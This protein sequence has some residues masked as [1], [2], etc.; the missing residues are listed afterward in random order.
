MV[1]HSHRSGCTDCHLLAAY[2]RGNK[3]SSNGLIPEQAIASNKH[4]LII[5]VYPQFAWLM[6]TFSNGGGVSSMQNPCPTKICSHFAPPLPSSS[7]H[8]LDVRKYH[9]N[10][11]T[12]L[13][14]YFSRD[15][16]DGNPDWAVG[17]I[18]IRQPRLNLL[19]KGRSRGDNGWSKA[20]VN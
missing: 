16:Y 13:D 7:F 20:N 19:T 3:N 12:Q 8:T 17:S 18:L 6:V 11:I 15:S 2:L 5:L 14:Y 9:C 10:N 4:K 1:W